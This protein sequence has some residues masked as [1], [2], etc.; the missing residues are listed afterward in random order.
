MS[1]CPWP[2]LCP[3][4]LG[5]L[6]LRSGHSWRLCSNRVTHYNTATHTHVI[7]KPWDDGQQVVN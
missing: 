1:S 3:T 6:M 2:M 4:V 7:L 5:I